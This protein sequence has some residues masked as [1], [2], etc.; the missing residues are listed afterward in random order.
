MN[1]FHLTFPLRL[2]IN[3]GTGNIVTVQ[4]DSAPVAQ[5]LPIFTD[6]HRSD[7]FITSHD[8]PRESVTVL[9]FDGPGTFV[10]FLDGIEAT[11]T[12]VAIDPSGPNVRFVAPDEFISQ[13]SEL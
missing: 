5:C 6:E 13:L 8:V 3:S 7:S 4:T 12:Y 10:E 11:L 2:I 1:K 9:A